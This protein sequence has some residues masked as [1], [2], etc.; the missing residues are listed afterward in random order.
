[1]VRVKFFVLNLRQNVG[2]IYWLD[3]LM[4]QNIVNIYCC[5]IWLSPNPIFFPKF[6]TLK[7]SFVNSRFFKSLKLIKYILK[8][9][10]PQ[11]FLSWTTKPKPPKI[12]QK[13]YSIWAS[14]TLIIFLQKYFFLKENKESDEIF[15]NKYH[16]SKWNVT[17]QTADIQNTQSEFTQGNALGKPIKIQIFSKKNRIY[18]FITNFS[19]IFHPSEK[20]HPL[21]LY[22]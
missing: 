13:Y 10:F 8:L 15:G 11:K 6:S 12:F 22:F 7:W 21:I 16:L 2:T 20:S 3:H 19:K 4:K 18:I 17:V 9:Y 1:M 5:I 14:S